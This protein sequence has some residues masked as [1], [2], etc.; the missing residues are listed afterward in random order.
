MPGRC[1]FQPGAVR[2]SNSLQPIATTHGTFSP[3]ALRLLFD[4]GIFSE[5]E[6]AQPRRR[7]RCIF[8]DLEALITDG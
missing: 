8:R 3:R 1:C 7:P 4:G 5:V 6:G 2:T